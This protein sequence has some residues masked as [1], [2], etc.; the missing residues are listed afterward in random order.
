M[1][2]KLKNMSEANSIHYRN[3]LQIYLIFSVS[4]LRNITESLCSLAFL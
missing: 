2:N 4:N 1:F 3:S